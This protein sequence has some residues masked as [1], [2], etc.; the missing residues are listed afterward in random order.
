MNAKSSKK[1]IQIIDEDAYAEDLYNDLIESCSKHVKV[2]DIKLIRKAFD[3]AKESHKGVKR[4][5]GEPYIVHPIAVAKIVTAEIGLGATA[6]TCALLHDVVEDTEYTLEDIEHF[7][8]EKIASI[9]DGLTKISGVF[10][11]RSSLQAENFRKCF[12]PYQMMFV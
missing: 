3:L 7:F 1:N 6:I 8:G 2:K 12:L 9:I 10:D 4:K 5:S 11:N